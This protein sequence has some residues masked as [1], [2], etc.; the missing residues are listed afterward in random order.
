MALRWGTLDRLARLRSDAC[1]FEVGEETP[2]GRQA[3]PF[4]AWYAEGKRWYAVP[5]TC[6]LLSAL[7]RS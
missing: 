1:S 7:A 3:C 4:W 6:G 2:L 5:Q